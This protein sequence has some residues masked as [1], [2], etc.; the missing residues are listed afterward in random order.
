MSTVNYIRQL[1]KC[2]ENKTNILTAYYIRELE[3]SNEK[4]ANYIRELE[5]YIEKKINYTRLFSTPTDCD[6]APSRDMNRTW[7]KPPCIITPYPVQ[8]WN[9]NQIL[10]WIVTS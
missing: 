2:I 3:E 8:A 1:E 7:D 4:K 5:E 9:R 6:P 10:H